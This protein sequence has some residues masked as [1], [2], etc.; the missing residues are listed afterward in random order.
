MND[1]QQFLEAKIKLAPVFGF[2]IDETEINPAYFLDSVSYL[3]A[4]EEQV[5]MPTLFDLAE[6]ELAA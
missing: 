5:S 2:E 6:L 4:A 1:Y 3:K